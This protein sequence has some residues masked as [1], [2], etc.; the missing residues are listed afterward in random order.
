MKQVFRWLWQQRTD[1]TGFLLL[2]ICFIFCTTNDQ[3]YARHKGTSNKCLNVF[4]NTQNEIYF[5][6][7]KSG[8]HQ[9]YFLGFIALIMLIRNTGIFI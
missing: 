6:P 1:M 7:I 8:A 4:Q 5:P 3:L 9:Y 2:R